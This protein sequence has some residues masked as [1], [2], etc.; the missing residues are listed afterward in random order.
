MHINLSFLMSD[1]KPESPF[2]SRRELPRTPTSVWSRLPGPV[3]RRSPS[4]SPDT[5]RSVKPNGKMISPSVS[6]DASP[7]L[8]TCATTATVSSTNTSK[9]A[10]KRNLA[11]S[12]VTK[13]ITGGGLTDINTFLSSDGNGFEFSRPIPVDVNVQTNSSHNSNS[14]I[15][16]TENLNVNET[17]LQNNSLNLNLQNPDNLNISSQ[18]TTSSEINN[19]NTLSTSQITNLDKSRQLAQNTSR[20]MFVS[21]ER[22]QSLLDE[23]DNRLLGKLK[24]LILGGKKGP[25][26]TSTTESRPVFSQANRMPFN[27]S[28]ASHITSISQPSFYL[29]NRSSITSFRDSVNINDCPLTNSCNSYTQQR[30]FA[31][32]QNAYA[33]IVSQPRTTQSTSAPRFC[34][35]SNLQLPNLPTSGLTQPLAG[36]LY[37]NSNTLPICF[38]FTFYSFYKN[39]PAQWFVQLEDQFSYR[40]VVD[41]EPKF[42]IVMKNLESDI[43][44]QIAAELRVVTVG[45][46]YNSLKMVLIRKFS[47]T[48]RQRLDKFLTDKL[49]SSK[50]SQFLSRLL[51]FGDGHLPRVSI[52]AAW[53]Q[54]L[55]AD[56]QFHLIDQITLE[57]ELSIVAKADLVFDRLKARDNSRVN[58]IAVPPEQGV[59]NGLLGDVNAINKILTNSKSAG[60]QR[61]RSRSKG[62]RVKHSSPDSSRSTSRSPERRNR[63]SSNNS[64]KGNKKSGLCWYHYKFRAKA[65]RCQSPCSWDPK[66]TPSRDSSSDSKLQRDQDEPKQTQKN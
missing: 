34:D 1:H 64:K 29:G 50:P 24:A 2:S 46:K 6:P 57:N 28:H 9:G 61:G 26:T 38:D 17:T 13:E 19:I 43:V 54:R 25:S 31:F 35:G 27:V 66:K 39:D 37:N 14:F 47:D 62:K 51:F 36:S 48:P 58:S 11:P 15:A 4:L 20:E 3:Y 18:I 21:E 42:N 7:V 45:N 44:K 16:N 23:R 22:L 32:N 65:K 60:A 63:D 8:S 30:E 33:S 5:G 53:Q 49:G 12:L 10:V 59:L 56:Y 40:G 52:L 41:D 55:P